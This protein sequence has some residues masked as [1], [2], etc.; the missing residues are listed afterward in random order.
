MLQAVLMGFG[1][2]G[3]GETGI[4]RGPPLLPKGWTRLTIRSAAP[5]FAPLIVGP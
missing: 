4:V 2:L 5:G 1:G 3:I